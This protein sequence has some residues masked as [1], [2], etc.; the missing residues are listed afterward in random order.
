MGGARHRRPRDAGRFGVPRGGVRLAGRAGDRCHRPPAGVRR[1][2]RR[3][4]R[5]TTDRVLLVLAA[6]ASGATQFGDDLFR[7]SPPYVFQIGWVL[8]WAP[9]RCW[10]TC[11][12]PTQRR[13]R[14]CGA[15]LFLVLAWTWPSPPARLGAALAAAGRG[16]QDFWF[17]LW[18]DN[19][20]AVADR[21]GLGAASRTGRL[22]HR[23]HGRSL[24]E[25]AGCVPR[26]CPGHRRGRHGSR[27][28]VLLRE[29]AF[30]ATARDWV[31]PDVTVLL[32]AAHNLT[33]GL[34]PVILV[35]VTLRAA[36][37]R[38]LIVEQL[39]SVAVIRRG[40]RM[41]SAPSWAIPR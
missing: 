36:T 17:T 20:A 40:S 30:L 6:I 11:S 13:P 41:P 14:C 22:V 18:E 16:G 37:Q 21:H 23:P 35:A 39:L 34:V 26:H 5:P 31:S 32:E 1:A 7:P 27:R 9:A 2:R 15:R 3:R 10:P 28:G 24:E 33:V 12:S 8:M 25:R 29:L 38:G 19:A 4:G